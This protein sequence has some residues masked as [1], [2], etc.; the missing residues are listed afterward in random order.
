MLTFIPP[1]RL[2]YRNI[3]VIFRT[4]TKNMLNYIA[5]HKKYIRLYLRDYKGS[6]E[7]GE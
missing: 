2:D 5:V 4:P 1:R 7:K 6:S 3:R